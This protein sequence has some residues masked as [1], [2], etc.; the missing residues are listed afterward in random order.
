M[1]NYFRFTLLILVVFFSFLSCEG[2]TTATVD[3]DYN[4]FKIERSAWENSN[5][6]NY[7]YNLSNFGG[8]EYVPINTLIIV[9]NGQ[10]KEQTPLSEY[11]EA[12]ENYQTINKVY[13]TIEDLYQ[14]YNNSQQSK[15]DFY[16]TKIKIEYD[17]NHVPLKT[18][19][20]YYVP[21]N[22]M[23]MSTYWLYEIENYRNNSK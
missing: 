5:P 18:E 16:L 17:S 7:Q 14:R 4:K 15:K 9:E 10:F 19:Y 2:L 6:L 20:Y 1:K 23:D 3:F 22:L 8:G 12:G 11:G 13:E 21:Q